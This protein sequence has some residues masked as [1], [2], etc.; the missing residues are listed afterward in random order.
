MMGFETLLN[1]TKNSDHF[2]YNW[3]SRIFKSYYEMFCKINF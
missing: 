3:K 2:E 1:V